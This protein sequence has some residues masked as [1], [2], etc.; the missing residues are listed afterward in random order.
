MNILYDETDWQDKSAFSTKIISIGDKLNIELVIR[1]KDIEDKGLVIILNC[2]SFSKNENQNKIIWLIP[3]VYDNLDITSYLKIDNDTQSSKGKNDKISN[4]KS[5]SNFLTQYEISEIID[6]PNL[7][8]IKFQSQIK[9]FK[10]GYYD[11]N[12]VKFSKGRMSRIK[13]LE[14]P[15]IIDELK[16]AKGRFIAI[17]KTIKNYSLHEVFADLTNAGIDKEKGKIMR[18]GTFRDIEKKLE[19][20]NQRNINCLYLMG[21]LERDN[22]ICFDCEEKNEILDIQNPEASPMAVTCRAS[23]SNLLGGEVAFNSLVE[24]AKKYSIKIIIDS[25]TRISSS[26]HHRKYRNILLHTLDRDGKLNFCYGTDGHS[27]NY[28]DTAL[29]NYRKVE[30]WEILV[31]DIYSIIQK[32]NIDGVHLDNCQSWPQMFDIDHE[33][34]LRL[35]P[36]GKQAYSSEEILNGEIVIRS[37]DCGYWSSDLI[38]EY[39]NPFLIKLTRSIWKKFPNFLF[40]GECWAT[41]QFQ[42]RHIV[43]AKS[44]IIPRMYTLPRALSSVFGRKIHRNGYIENCKPEPVSII[45]DMLEE[46]YQFLPEGALTI[47]SSCGQVWPYPALLYGRGNWSAIDLLFS[48]P[49]IPM[50]F[51]DEIDGEAFRVKIT[52]IYSSK[53]LPKRNSGLVLKSKSSINLEK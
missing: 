42:N 40:I 14:S 22:Q 37:E 15:K 33:E 27:V 5:I 4:N 20:F 18:R 21:A 39:P 8:L 26:R 19:E 25:L 16:E 49:D 43:L 52:N 34:M 31:E 53:E 35:D 46:N 6:N 10:S 41:N 30:S 7:V 2:P 17:D 29:L 9:I 36:D 48:L 1:R 12:L 23:I 45:K 51:M 32:Y 47:L 11:W 44:G 13:Y 50:T 3:K 38:D 28:E 24:R